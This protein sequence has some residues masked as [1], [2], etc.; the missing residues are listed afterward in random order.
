MHP[1]QLSVLGLLFDI[2]GA[3]FLAAEAIKIENLCAMRD[4]VLRRLRHA[5]IS[6]PFA[7]GDKEELTPERER[8]FREAFE[9]GPPWG[10]KHPRLFT[11]LH[12]IAGILVFQ[13]GNLLF[14]N[15]F[16]GWLLA[17]AKWILASTPPVIAYAVILLL[18]AWLILGGVWL[19]GEIV[20]VLITQTIH[21][22]IKVIEFIDRR[23]ADGGV[24][25]LGF[26]L[27]FV[28]F[29]LQLLGTVAAAPC[30]LQG[31]ASA[32]LAATGI[33]INTSRSRTPATLGTCLRLPALPRSRPRPR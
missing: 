28:G 25:I 33:R 14:D 24:G 17:A 32:H 13:A 7:L 26:L 18:A 1:Y 11:L 6:P 5:T 3:F 10:A 15:R 30:L 31:A 19:L 9:F 2:V 22:P 8:Y 23:T 4:K 27:L 20:H 12:Y 21:L 16:I 29:V